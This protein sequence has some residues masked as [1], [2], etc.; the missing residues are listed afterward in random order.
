[1][2]INPQGSSDIIHNLRLVL[3][4]RAADDVPAFKRGRM[5]FDF[6][7]GKVRVEAALG[8]R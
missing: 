1:M 2:Q 6:T 8:V 4:R 3:D 5:I 7:T